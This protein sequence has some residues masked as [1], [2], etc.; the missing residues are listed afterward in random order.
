MACLVCSL[1][2]IYVFRIRLADIHLT[3]LFLDYVIQI[4]E[5]LKTTFLC[6]QCIYFKFQI[7]RC[8]ITL[9]R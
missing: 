7:L 2:L 1:I 5:I 4:T 6:F 8:K 9:N 3:N